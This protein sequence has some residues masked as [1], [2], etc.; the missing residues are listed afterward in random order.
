MKAMDMKSRIELELRGKD[1]ST[2]KELNLDSCRAQQFDG[3][4]DDF[5][6]LE[7]LSL[8]NVGLTSLKGFPKLPNLKK[9]ELSD[10][11]VSSGL[12]Y[13]LGCQSL[14]HLNLSGNKFKEIE[15]L[16]ALAK[17]SSLT[18]LDLFNCDVTQQDGYREKI[19]KQLPN[20]KYLDGFDQN[21]QEEDEFE[22]DN[23]SDD[24]EDDEED[25]DEEDDEDDDDDE[26]EEDDEEAVVIKKGL[27]GNGIKAANGK[28]NGSGSNDEEDED[29]EEED[30]NEVGLSYLQKSNLG[31]DEDDEDFDAQKAMNQTEDDDED[32]EED[33]D[34]ADEVDENEVQEDVSSSRSRKRKHDETG[35]EDSKTN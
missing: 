30:E 29:D 14:T 4:T 33:E 13:L 22:G 20:L 17:I 25:D 7:I 32:E 35:D 6:S 8:I 5:Q 9:L 1:A 27:N 16:A 11:R 34:V 23:E 12:D 10:N 24:D 3:L 26:E 15:S 19:F 21:E 18:N 31:D 2:I 28:K